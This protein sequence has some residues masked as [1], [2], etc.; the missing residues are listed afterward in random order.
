[1]P[2]DIL[3][4]RLKD[5]LNSPGVYLFKDKE[6]RV[7]YIGK[8]NNIKNRILNHINSPL[9]TKSFYIV[10]ESYDL[11]VI[12]TQNETKAFLLE[13]KLIKKYQ[14]KYNVQFK[15]DKTYPYLA[16]TKEEYPR[17]IILRKDNKNSY[18][19]KCGPFI[20]IKF[21]KNLKEFL[22][23]TFKLRTCQN[24]KKR[25]CLKYH[26]GEC[27]APCINKISKKEYLENLNLALKVLKGD[28]S[29][30]QENLIE[31]INAY[32][33]KEEFEKALFYKNVL[34]AIKNI[35][36][37]KDFEKELKITSLASLREKKEN[38]NINIYKLSNDFESL[39]NISFPFRAEG[40]DISSFYGKINVGSCVVFINGRPEKSEY[41]KYY[42]K[43]KGVDDYKCLE[44]LLFRRFRR[45]KEEKIDTDL[46][47]IDGGKGQLNLAKRLKN[48][49]GLNFYLVALAKG[50]T[51]KNA[52][53]YTEDG[54]VL[55]LFNY[56]ELLKYF[57]SIRDE[58]HRFAKNYLWQKVKKLQ[59][60]DVLSDIKGLGKKRLLALKNLYKNLY[61]LSQASI[62]ELVNIGIPKNV[63]Q[64]I[65]ERLK[66]K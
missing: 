40:F 8:S 22:E 58:A 61:E 55:D 16:V 35:Y 37:S 15:D 11:E 6:G 48:Y 43:I 49:F 60:E 33:E 50:E 41:R 4:E 34:E 20:N 36:R 1:M 31:F 7:I 23:K 51:R 53:L 47:L 54:K 62:Q 65:L 64:K 26:I 46:I 57:I 28:I 24:L 30:I 2:R 10:N 38:I 25:A 27:S 42:L 44:E 14:P 3:L 45:I 52:I 17:L 66:V 32:A 12:Y 18:I 19:Y 59:F 63:A 13:E 29:S 56:P 5:I 39:L 21:A 9:G